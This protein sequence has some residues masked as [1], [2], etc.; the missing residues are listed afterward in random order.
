M[1]GE[2]WDTKIETDPVPHIIIDNFLSNR[3]NREFLAEAI[4]LEPMYKTSGVGSHQSL[5]D[6]CDLCKIKGKDL[7]LAIREN[8]V[9]FLSDHYTGIPIERVASTIL[10]TMDMITKSEAIQD[11][12]VKVGGLF[13]VVQLT[14]RLEVIVSRYG[15]CDFYGFHRDNGGPIGKGRVL[16]LVYYFNKP[17]AKFTGGELILTGDDVHDRV[18]VKPENNR[19]VIFESKSVHAVN[20]VELESHDFDEGRF[21]LNIWLGF[22]DYAE[23][24]VTKEIRDEV[25]KHNKQL[26]YKELKKELESDT[27]S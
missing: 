6:G 24:T 13:S 15:K 27:K 8:D 19:A 9:V 1:V 17:N 4:E 16:T 10:R 2:M 11:L 23:M 7:N 3:L 5:H 22:Q 26:Q 21:S 20:T 18:I 12:L 25:T 14:D